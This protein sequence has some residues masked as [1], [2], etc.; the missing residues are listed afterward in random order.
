MPEAWGGA[1]DTQ[2]S[3]GS[4]R[5]A[6]ECI[7]DNCSEDQFILINDQVWVPRL[8]SLS[9]SPERPEIPA[10]YLG[11][12]V[13]I[14]GGLGAIGMRLA[15]H[16]VSHGA[17]ELVLV[18]RAMQPTADQQ[19]TLD[20]WKKLGVSVQLLAADVSSQEGMARLT[21]SLEGKQIDSILHTAGVDFLSPIATWNTADVRRVTQ[22]KIQGSWNLH[23]WSLS[24]PVQR[25]VL[26][27]SIASVWGAPER[28]LY[29]SANAFLDAL[30]DYRVSQKLPVTV[31]NFGPWAD[32]GMA[33]Q[34]SLD[35][36]ARVG[37]HGLEPSQT[38]ASIGRL[39][40]QGVAQAVIT[41]TQW[42]RFVSVM[43]ARRTRPFFESLLEDPS[44]SVTSSAPADRTGTSVAVGSTV[45]GAAGAAHESWLAQLSGLDKEGQIG[46]LRRLVRKE[47]SEVLKSQEDRI[48]LDRSM[49]RLGLDSITAVELSMRL[50]KSTGIAAGKWLAGEP[51]VESVAAGMLD[52]LQSRLVSASQSSRESRA[53]VTGVRSAS[54]GAQGA[55]GKS[56]LAPWASELSSLAGH[57]RKRERLVDLFGREL[58]RFTGKS[59]SKVSGSTRMADLGLDSLGAVDF[60]T[61][62]RKQMGLAAP[63]RLMQYAAVGDWVRSVVPS[64]RDE[65]AAV[66]FR[67]NPSI[68]GEGVRVDLYE[69]SMHKQV[70]EFC[71]QAW[72]ARSQGSIE[73]RWDWMFQKSAQRLGAS[74]AVWL[75]RDRGQIIGHMGSQFTTLKT[76]GGQIIVP[77]FVDTM[78]LEQYRQ[79]GI[80]SQILLQAEEDMPMALSLGQTAEIRRILDSL[81]WKQ[82][83]PLH[84]HTF[85]IRPDRVMRGK[86]PMGV[87]RLAAAYLGFSRARRKALHASRSKE[88]EVRRIQR[89][90]SRHDAIWEQMSRG[91]SCLAVRD[92]SY[93][94]W[95]YVDQPGQ[96][97]EC[98]EVFLSKRLL[99][100]FVTKTEEP[101][102]VY[103]Y[104]RSNWVDMVCAMEPETID[105][106]IHGCIFS[107]EKHGADAISIHLTHRLIE[108]R[109]LAQ[110]F[111]AR[112]ETRYLYASRGLTESVPGLVD[113]DWLVNQ[114]DSDIDRPQ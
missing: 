37:M 26:T 79:R 11:Q 94:N 47:L 67:G 101:N 28:F 100:V 103:A 88:L 68:G 110:G 13:L 64:S 18:G 48:S 17:R 96:R 77:W 23:Q 71:K 25:F 53:G 112:Q 54:T 80:G 46:E 108:E 6:I 85:M 69:S 60:A 63:P 55:I 29:A 14:T 66:G 104:R 59:G 89:F 75:A 58:E 22:A 33:D 86:L 12:R 56:P 57:E 44:L 70:I 19:K 21:S 35:E 3:P 62:V 93:L 31:L 1:I 102:A 51:T 5:R 9:I 106:V 24:H 39:L 109:L 74:P 84:I 99:G 92:S 82:I 73:Q 72:P 4:M 43:S 27:S 10:N 45:V 52:G 87:H 40:Q 15:E 50:K 65:G 111:F 38:I 34:K 107:S 20:Q 7:G 8:E 90:D 36:Y 95:K 2:D 49:Y 42:D 41:D 30:G 78:V 97:F 32:G 76:P 114:G 61:H 16:A 113:F 83:C 105:T 91:V 98:W 81:G